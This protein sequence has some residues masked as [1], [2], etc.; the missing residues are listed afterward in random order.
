[1]GYRNR[2]LE[3][4]QVQ[5]GWG[6]PSPTPTEIMP[7]TT[8]AKC[9]LQA[10]PVLARLSIDTLQISCAQ[11]AMGTGGLRVSLERTFIRKGTCRQILMELRKLRE[12]VPSH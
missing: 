12:V 8:V 4:K 6:T 10:R 1:M 3:S 9:L 2:E 5:T 7:D 11:T